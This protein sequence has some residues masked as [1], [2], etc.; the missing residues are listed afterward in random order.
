M[1]SGDKCTIFKTCKI[2]NETKWYKHFPSKGKGK[3][4]SYCKKCKFRKHEIILPSTMYYFDTSILQNNHIRVR[5]KSESKNGIQYYTSKRKA[6]LLVNE[7]MAGI[8]NES[9]IHKFYDY[10]AFKLLILKRDKY[11]CGYCEEYGNTLDHIIPKSKGGITSFNNC[12]CAC[13]SCN[14]EK[15]SMPLDQYLALINNNI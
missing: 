7:G 5:I 11:T 3:K 9:L 6:A 2:C 10:K 12:I 4:E 8:V 1:R 15:G 14:R 13:L